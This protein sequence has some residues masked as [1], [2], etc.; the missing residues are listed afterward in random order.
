MIKNET[1]QFTVKKISGGYILDDGEEHYLTSANAVA[2]KI[3]EILD[4][5]KEEVKT[6]QRSLDPQQQV[7]TTI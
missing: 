5:K 4:P 2:L 6:R 3:K 7:E 1:R